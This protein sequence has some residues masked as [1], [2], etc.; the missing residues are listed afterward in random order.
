MTVEQQFIVEEVCLGS[1]MMCKKLHCV[2]V[3]LSRDVV[4]H[5]QGADESQV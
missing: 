1:L 5:S 4:C 2:F 3:K